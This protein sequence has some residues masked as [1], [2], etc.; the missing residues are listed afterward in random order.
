MENKATGGALFLTCYG[1]LGR[2]FQ[3][4]LTAVCKADLGWASQG[5]QDCM[6]FDPWDNNAWASLQAYTWKSYSVPGS[7]SSFLKELFCA[8]RH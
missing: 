8:R 4:C 2:L 1:A 6:L 3:L 7:T 5:F